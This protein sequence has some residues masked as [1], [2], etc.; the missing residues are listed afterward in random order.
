MARSNGAGE[1]QTAAL[2]KAETDSSEWTPEKQAALDKVLADKVGGAWDSEAPQTSDFARSAAIFNGFDPNQFRYAGP[3]DFDA[4]AVKVY[5]VDTHRDM[6]M[7]AA[8]PF[9]S[10]LS[11]DEMNRL[12]VG[13]AWPD[14]PRDDP[15][16]VP[17]QL[18]VVREMREPGT[19]AN[20][21]HYGGLSVLHSMTPSSDFTNGEVRDT[22]VDQIGLLYQRAQT[23]GDLKYLGMAIHP[24]VDSYVLSHTVREDLGNGQLG[25]IVNFQNYNDQNVFRHMTPETVPTIDGDSG[26]WRD[27]PGALQAFQYA[28]KMI[29]FYT[30]G[31]DVTTVKEYL[32]NEVYKL[33]PGAADRQAGGTLPQYRKLFR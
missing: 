13:L 20:M 2:N 28:Q 3:S 29:E 12:K 7:E 23:E 4:Q 22:I 6:G 19:L 15:Y 33:A 25:D 31:E 16:S 26:S 18:S 11:K 10:S 32:Q 17:S 9:E 14:I 30:Q 1:Q 27:L 8:K 24:G 5:D 21:L